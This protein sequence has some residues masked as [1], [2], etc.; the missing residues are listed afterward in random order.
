MLNHSGSIIDR[1]KIIVK[2]AGKVAIKQHMLT[3]TN[4][5]VWVKLRWT[6]APEFNN[7]NQRTQI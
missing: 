2:W 1:L 5:H 6:D 7:P 4:M 3:C